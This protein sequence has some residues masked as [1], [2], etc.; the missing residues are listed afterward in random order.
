[1]PRKYKSKRTYFRRYKKKW[2]P[3]NTEITIPSPAGQLASNYCLENGVPCIY[4]ASNSLGNYAA[5]SDAISAINYYICRPRFKGVIQSPV[6]VGVSYIIYLCYVPNAA[7]ID[8]GANPVALAN[9]RSTYFYLHP[10]YVLAWTRLDYIAN[11]GDTGEV[12][13]YTRINKR[14]SPGDRLYLV[15]LARNDSNAAATVYPVQGTFSCYLRT[16]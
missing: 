5:P 10:E 2:T 3:Y 9:L 7:T 12:S 16:N 14:I 4:G 6:A 13:L 11:S 8:N 1:M 15:A